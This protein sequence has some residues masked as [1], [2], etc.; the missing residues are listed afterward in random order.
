MYKIGV[1]DLDAIVCRYEYKWNIK[2]T[3]NLYIAM[4]LECITVEKEAIL[5][6]DE[7]MKTQILLDRYE[8]GNN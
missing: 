6:D 5:Y 2:K 7:M 3:T 4:E 1:F 8:C